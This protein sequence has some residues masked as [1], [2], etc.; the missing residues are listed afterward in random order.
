MVMAKIHSFYMA[1]VSLA[2][3]IFT[4]HMQFISQPQET[5]YSSNVIICC[6]CLHEHTLGSMG[7]YLTAG[8]SLFCHAFLKSLS[9]SA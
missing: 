2:G 3:A 5:A 9:Y 8:L 7:S 6:I 4:L 1:T